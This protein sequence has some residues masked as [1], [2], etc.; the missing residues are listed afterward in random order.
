M[1]DE[2]TETEWTVHNMAL[3]SKTGCGGIRYVYGQMPRLQRT[4]LRYYCHRGRRAVLKVRCP[5]C[6]RIVKLEWLLQV[7]ETAK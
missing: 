4:D 2:G 1:D 3:S 6:G 7:T 5:E